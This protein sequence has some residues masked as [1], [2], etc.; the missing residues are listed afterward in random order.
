[1]IVNKT[2][3]YRVFLVSNMEIDHAYFMNQALKEAHKAFEIDEVP[4]GVVVVNNNRIIARAHNLVQRLTDPT[5]HAEMQA[6]TSATN[7][8]N[9]K[10]LNHCILYTTLE[11]CTMCAG[12]L[13]WSQLG[14]L[15]FASEDLQ[16]GYRSQG[17]SLH[18]KC[19]V[20]KGIMQNQA[21]ELLNLFFQ[22]K[23]N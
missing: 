15:V 14:H 4:I 19:Q 1:M 10:Y 23:R 11:P 13:Y 8:L 21:T 5:A 18:P 2:S 20:T 12:A 22:K 7:Y 9:S 17:V 6:I 3:S 16:K